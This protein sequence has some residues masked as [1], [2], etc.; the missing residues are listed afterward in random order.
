VSMWTS[1]AEVS[2]SGGGPSFTGVE[3]FSGA[4]EDA[5]TGEVT[6]LAAGISGHAGDASLSV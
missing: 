4:G 2:C 3:V 6:G 1:G 5:R